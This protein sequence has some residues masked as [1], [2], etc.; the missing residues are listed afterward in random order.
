MRQ[1]DGVEQ[2]GAGGVAVVGFAAVF[3]EA[4][5]GVG[6]VVDHGGVEAAG[7]EQAVD[8]LAEAAVAEQDDGV[9]LFNHVLRALL[10][11]F[12]DAARCNH[13]VLEDK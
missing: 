3:G 8:L 4:F 5:H 1:A 2:F 6:L 11:F 12:H 9:F 13:F 10:V 7:G